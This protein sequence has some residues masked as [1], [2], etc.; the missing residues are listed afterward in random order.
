MLDFVPTIT[1]NLYLQ[2]IFIS[3]GVESNKDVYPT[4]IKLFFRNIAFHCSS[5]H[6]RG[7]LSLRVTKVIENLGTEIA[8]SEK[9]VNLLHLRKPV[10]HS[11]YLL[12]YHFIPIYVQ[13]QYKKYGT[14]ISCMNL[15]STL[16]QR[17]K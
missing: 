14:T 12:N 1:E 11:A 3:T 7:C 10:I 6:S 17:A 4:C 15:L 5:L 8:Y 16:Y 2:D 9:L 13:Q